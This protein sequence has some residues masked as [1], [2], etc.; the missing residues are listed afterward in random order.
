MGGKGGRNVEQGSGFVGCDSLGIA[1]CGMRLGLWRLELC[2]IQ[3]A[4]AK[5]V[6]RP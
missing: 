2:L 1:E 3:T 6:D 4:S 5:L